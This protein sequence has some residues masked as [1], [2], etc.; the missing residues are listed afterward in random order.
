MLAQQILT[1]RNLICADFNG[2]LYVVYNNVIRIMSIIM[3]THTFFLN[4]KRKKAIV[5]VF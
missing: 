4:R 2:Y 1:L 5:C 3:S